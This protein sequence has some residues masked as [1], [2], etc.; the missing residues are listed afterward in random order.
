MSLIISLSALLLSVIFIQ[1]GSGSLGPLDAL[2]GQSNGFTA[3]QI[4]LLGSSHFLGLLIGCFIYPHLIRR[5]GHVRIFA[6]TASISAISAL[7]HPLIIDVF[8]WCMLRVMTGFSIA[9]AYTIIESWLQAKLT[10]D[11]R[12]RVF[13]IY[14]VVDMSGVVLAQ[15]VIAMLDPATYAAYNIIAVVACLSL[16]PLALTRSVPPELP[17]TL[18]FKPFFALRLSPLAGLGV[19]S[20][21]MTNASFRMVGPVYAIETGLEA[22]DIAIFLVLG[23]VGGAF[24]QVPAG[25][26]TDRFN[27][28]FVLIGFSM[29]AIIVCLIT[30]S[31]SFLGLQTVMVGFLMAF[32]FGAATMPIYSICATHANDFAK[33]DELVELSASLILLFSIGAI[34]SPVLCGYLI[35]NFNAGAMFLFIA[36]VHIVLVTYSVWRMG[37]RPALNMSSY[38]YIPRTSVFINFILRERGNAHPENTDP[39]KANS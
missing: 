33:I 4:G 13:G 24:I 20:A 10:N 15:G 5:S 19:I 9:G 34:L 29:A 39:E 23:V 7:L 32:L 2:A 3:G 31:L 14:R 16:M 36:S 8:F 22:T 21:G 27:R 17:A 26:I 28:R 25:Y 38:R 1:V 12:G 18:R 30:G 37:I 11:N 6:M 35:E